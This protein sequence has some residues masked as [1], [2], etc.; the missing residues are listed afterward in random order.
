MAPPRLAGTR[1]AQRNGKSL[2]TRRSQAG[3][4]RRG[5]STTWLRWNSS[6]SFLDY[7]RLNRNAS[8][9]TVA[10]VRRA[11]CRS[12]SRSPPTHAGQARRARSRRTSISALIRGFLGGAVPPGTGA[13]VGRAQALGAA[14]VR[15]LPAPRRL[16][17]DRSRGARG[18]AEARA[19]GAGASLGRRDVAAA[20]DARR[21]DAARP[22]RPRHPRAVL[23]VGPASERARRRSISRTSNLPARMVRVHGEGPQGAHRAVQHDGAER[24]A[25]GWMPDRAALRRGTSAQARRRASQGANGPETPLFVNA[26]GGTADRPQRAAPRRAV[27]Q[28]LQHAVRHQPARAAAF[29]RHAPA[30]ARRRPARHPGAARPR[31]AVDD[32]A[33]HARQRRAA[34]RGL[35]E[36]AS[37]ARTNP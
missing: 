1:S 25:R 8:P 10:R 37:R 21:V 20:R 33:L 36:G 4:V 31:A 22:P 13:R 11:T 7:L 34:A 32:A 9:H 15:P 35:P 30:A 18:R 19:E 14:D 5:R 12:S 16:D 3:D 28:Q 23:R 2:A 17:R 24:A 27:R 6:A 29:V 26:R